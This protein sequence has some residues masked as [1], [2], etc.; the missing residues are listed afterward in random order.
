MGNAQNLLVVDKRK[1][2]LKERPERDTG[3]MMADATFQ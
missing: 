2:W 1:E 3:G